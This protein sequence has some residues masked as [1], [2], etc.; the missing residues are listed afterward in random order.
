MIE[1]GV[2]F[3]AVKSNLRR[4]K[5]GFVGVGEIGR[6]RLEAICKSGLADICAIADPEADAAMKAAENSPDA[7]IGITF[8]E[9][10]SLE[11]DGIVIATPS[12]LHASQSL[13]ALES[14]KAVFCQAPL[15]GSSA[16]IQKII[17][18]AKARN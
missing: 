13:A 12:E 3:P 11:L 15:A 16:E 6:N 5:L 10:L 18:A 8:D 17:D 4:P 1:I 7:L 2:L 14:D 9:M